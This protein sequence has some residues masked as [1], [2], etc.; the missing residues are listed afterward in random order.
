MKTYDLTGNLRKDVG[1]KHSKRLR[2][3]KMVP[4]VMYGGE[5]II[6]F[7]AF[8]NDFQNLVFTPNVYIVN[9]DIDG[10]KFQAILRDYQLHP[11]SDHILHA[12]FIQIFEDKDVIIRIPIHL[13]GSSIG[14]REGG[15]L[16][17]RRRY[18]KVKGLPKNLPDFLKIDISEMNI[19]DVIK[20]GDLEYEDLELLDPYRAMVV[21]VVSSRLVSKAMRELVEEVAEEEVE[22]EEGVEGEEGAEEATPAEGEGGE[23]PEKQQEG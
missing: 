15:K 8:E 3:E 16:R 6:H 10:K 12:D 5:E 1:K 2:K 22:E 23:T 20:I 11:V 18:L 21:S 13:T 19:G 4:C 7:A 14:I 17:Q 9:L